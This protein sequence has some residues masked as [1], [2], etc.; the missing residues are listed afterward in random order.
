MAFVRCRLPPL[1]GPRAGL[2]C[3][4][5]HNYWPGT[6]APFSVLLIMVSVP[7]AFLVLCLV[8]DLAWAM[9]LNIRKSPPAS[10]LGSSLEFSRIVLWG[11]SLSDNGNGTFLYSN[12]SWPDD[13]GYFK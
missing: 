6:R 3:A 11:D 7:R 12:R 13:P 10:V 8:F 9:P 4:H 1:D 5:H 2:S